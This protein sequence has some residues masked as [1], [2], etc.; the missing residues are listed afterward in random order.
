MHSLF[1]LIDYRIYLFANGKLPWLW[2][3]YT[4]SESRMISPPAF[5]FFGHVFCVNPFYALRF[6][7]CVLLTRRYCALEWPLFIIAELKI[8]GTVDLRRFSSL[9]TWCA[10]GKGTFFFSLSQI[11]LNWAFPVRGLHSSWTFPNGKHIKV[12]FL[13]RDSEFNWW[14]ETW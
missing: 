12:L 9:T 10:L 1:C 14:T 11:P 8:L 6:V 2:W 7:F 5:I 4:V 3:L 13:V